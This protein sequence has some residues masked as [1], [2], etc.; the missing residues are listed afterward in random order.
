MKKAPRDRKNK[1]KKRKKKEKKRGKEE[2]NRTP[3]FFRKET[4]LK[5][6]KKESVDLGIELEK[7]F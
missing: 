4:K 3:P 7:S 2:R 5:H 6:V 1:K